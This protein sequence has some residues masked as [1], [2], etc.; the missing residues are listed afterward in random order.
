[1]QCSPLLTLQFKHKANAAKQ[2][3]DVLLAGVG[4]ASMAIKN[5]SKQRLQHE[6][7]ENIWQTLACPDCLG[8]LEHAGEGARCL[9]CG[10]MY[11]RVDS[12]ALD[13]RLPYPKA[14]FIKHELGVNPLPEYDISVEP[15]SE[16]PRPEVDFADVKLPHNLSAKM[17][18]Y[19]P[20]ATSD[21]SLM[22]DLGCG[23]PIYREIAEA[24]GFEYV[25]LDFEVQQAPLLGDAQS[26]PFK[27]E[28]FEFI[29]SNAMFQY[30][31]SPAAMMAEA[32]RVLQAG[33]MFMGTV[34]FM[35]PFD[36]DSFYMPTRLGIVHLLHQAG[37]K[38]LQ[39]A[40][41]SWWTGLVAMSRMGLFPRM[42]AALTRALV[43]PLETM[44]KLWWRLGMRKGGQTVEALRLARV[45]GGHQFI[46]V[47]A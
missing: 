24:A 32:Y 17:R 4:S 20:K 25:G 36:G 39:V 27:D 19:F 18:S 40:P 35:E 10:T 2:K 11:H 21:Y 5:Y 29:W 41:D 45:T 7:S 34:G 38:V 31:P 26:M 46:A 1:M 3:L 30:V 33:G 12:G 8:T 9:R 28:S 15:L 13:L 43:M 6:Y 44:S 42:P 47:K 23:E 22:L 14:V 37:F 16:N